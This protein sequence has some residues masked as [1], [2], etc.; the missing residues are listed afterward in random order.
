MFTIVRAMQ[1]GAQGQAGIVA[2]GPHKSKATRKY[3]VKKPMLQYTDVRIM[4][5]CSAER[6][7][8]HL[9]YVHIRCRQHFLMISQSCVY[10]WAIDFEVLVHLPESMT[11]VCEPQRLWPESLRREFK[12]RLYTIVVSDSGSSQ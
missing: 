11:V 4:R 2:A 12:H 6:A 1:H 9:G 3:T 5:W 8:I 7:W 10:I